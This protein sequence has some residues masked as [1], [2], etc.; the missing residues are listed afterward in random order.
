MSLTFSEQ[1]NRCTL[2]HLDMRIHVLD[3]TRKSLHLT[4]PYSK[5]DAQCPWD[6]KGFLTILTPS[7]SM[8][9]KSSHPLF[10]PGDK[11]DVPLPLRATKSMYPPHSGQQNRCTSPTLGDK[12]DVPPPLR[13]TKSMYPSPSNKKIDG[14][15]Y[16]QTKKSMD[17]GSTCRLIFATCQGPNSGPHNK[18]VTTSNHTAH[19]TYIDFFAKPRPESQCTWVA[20][21]H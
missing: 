15:P 7:P 21:V 12:I 17:K 5:I 3:H 9:G 11:I 18:K 14:P 4:P 10:T 19:T 8:V 13:A 2:P 16:L 20:H 6:T 1:Q